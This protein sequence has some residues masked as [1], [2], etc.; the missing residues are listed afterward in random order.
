MGDD[1][2]FV[3]AFAGKFGGRAVED[4]HERVSEVT[5]ADGVKRATVAVG[6]FGIRLVGGKDLSH[7]EAGLKSDLPID[8]G[9]E[10]RAAD[11]ASEFA[12]G[13][14]NRVPEFF[15]SEASWREGREEGAIGVDFADLLKFRMFRTPLPGFAGEDEAVE[16]FEGPA[17]FDEPGCEVVKKFGMAGF[18]SH[19]SETIGGGNEAAPKV[20]GPDPVDDD[21]GGE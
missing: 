7:R 9:V 18:G 11:L 10:R 21:A 14:E 16:F 17:V 4:L 13:D 5:D 19:R 3:P 20:P 8:L 1:G 6:S 2:G 12:A 15:G